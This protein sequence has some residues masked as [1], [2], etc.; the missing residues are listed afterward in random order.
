MYAYLQTAQDGAARTVARL[1]ARDRRRF[2]PN[3]VT[4]AAPPA[5]GFFALAA[6]PA[7]YALERAAW[8]EAVELTPKRTPFPHTEAMTYFARAL[9]AAH[10]GRRR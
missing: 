9:G 4:G 7:R 3:A 10:C 8:T 1:A 5:A 2:D 6:I